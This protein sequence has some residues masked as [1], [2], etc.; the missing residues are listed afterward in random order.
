MAVFDAGIDADVAWLAMQALPGSDLVRYT[1]A[2]R[3]LPTGVVLRLLAPVADALAHAHEQGVLHRDL[4][5]ANVMVDWAAGGH[6]TLVDL[7]LARSSQ[8]SHD[9]AASHTGTGTGIVLGTPAYMAPEA[10]AGARPDARGDLYALGVMAFELLAGRRPHEA[11]SLG[12]LLNRVATQA[13]PDLRECAPTVPPALAALVAQLLATRP[14]AR[15]GSARLV[16]HTLA[17]T[18]AE[19]AGRPSH[20]PGD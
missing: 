20:P 11:A 9:P 15:P 18:L 12:E 2:Q 16:A 3:L 17:D 13:A 10:L 6:A 8:A 19:L 14:A 4:K 7:G 1:Q 5:P